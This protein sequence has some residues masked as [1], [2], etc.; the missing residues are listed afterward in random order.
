MFKDLVDREQVPKPKK[1]KGTCGR[2]QDEA[3]N[4]LIIH[5]YPKGSPI[6]V[7]MALHWQGLQNPS[8]HPL[9]PRPDS[10]DLDFSMETTVDIDSDFLHSMLAEEEGLVNAKEQGNMNVRNGQGFGVASELDKW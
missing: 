6:S 5:C 10:A 9:P 4:T 2:P 3:M 1:L 8:G 7:C